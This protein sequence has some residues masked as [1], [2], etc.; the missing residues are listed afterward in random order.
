M[1]IKVPFNDLRKQYLELKNEI[2]FVIQDVIDKSLFVRGTY[3]EKFEDMFAQEIGVDHCISVANGTDALYIAMKA[4]GVQEGDEVIVPAHS[5][6]STS[7]TVTQANGKVIFC[8]TYL[9][10]FTIDPGEIERKITSR[11]VGIIPVHL[12]GQPADM[13]RITDIAKKYNLWIIEDCAQAHLAKFKGKTVGTFGNAATFSFYPGKNLGAMGD[14]GAIVTNDNSIAEKAAMFARHGGLKKGSHQIEG[15]NSRMDGI[16]AAIL[17]VKLPH[18]RSWTNDRQKIA[19][20][21]SN[22]L[23]D[24]KSLN[25]PKTEKDREHVWHLYVI[26]H[27]KRDS[28][29]KH[30]LENG[31]QTVIN[32][33]IAL[34]FLPAYE[35]FNYNAK[36]FP[37]AFSNQSIILSLPIYPNMGDEVIDYISDKISLI[38]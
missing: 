34:P 4:L 22:K 18:L 11:T 28:L 24:L 9:D 38:D 25:I 3:V 10:T 2:N 15:V 19:E 26:K 23:K 35:K 13:D 33:P 14:A 27:A 30:L 5:W 17:S 7:E 12:Y 1:D 6:I 37:N 36:D 29:A 16:Q 31:I 32:Y 20:C 21:Y 8:D